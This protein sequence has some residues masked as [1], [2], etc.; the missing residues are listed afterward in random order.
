[1]GTTDSTFRNYS[2]HGQY[3]GHVDRWTHRRRTCSSIFTPL[4]SRFADILSTVVSISRL[5]LRHIRM[6]SDTAAWGTTTGKA[7]QGPSCCIPS[8]VRPGPFYLYERSEEAK[9][10]LTAVL[11]L[12]IYAMYNKN[13]WLAMFNGLL[14]VIEIIVMLVVYNVGIH[15]GTGNSAL[16]LS[17]LTAEIRTVFSFQSISARDAGRSDRML[18]YHRE[19]PVLHM[20]PRYAFTTTSIHPSF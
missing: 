16:D 4:K 13:K 11:Q 5:Y 18:R 14:F 2:P 12:R 8:K 15:A 9:P 3:R 10:D 6:L 19:I 20:D 7:P 1:M 17:K